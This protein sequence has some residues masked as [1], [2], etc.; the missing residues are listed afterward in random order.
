MKKSYK[1]F[2]LIELIVVITILSILWTIAFLSIRWYAQNS[3]DSVRIYDINNIKTSLELFKTKSWIYPEPSN[4][5][6]IFFSWSIAWSQWTFWESTFKNVWKLQKKPL[7]PLTLTEYTY[8]VTTKKNEYEIWTIIEWNISLNNLL[9]KS[10]ADWQYLWKSMIFWNYNWSVLSVSS[11]STLYVLA[12]PTIINWDMS[13]IDVEQILSQKKLAFNWSWNLPSSYSWSIMKWNWNFDFSPKKLVLFK[14]TKEELENNEAYKLILL[15]NIQL[16]YNW[17][18]LSQDSNL[19]PILSKQVN[20]YNPSENAKFTA[21]II[22]ENVTKQ[23][24]IDYNK[25]DKKINNK[26]NFPVWISKYT[27]CS[28]S[29][30]FCDD[31]IR[32]IF[33][34]SNWKMW[35]WSYEWWVWYFDWNNWSNYSVFDWLISNSI[36]SYGEDLNWNVWI[37]TWLWVSKA[38]KTSTWM[39]FEN[40]N[41]SD[42]LVWWTIVSISKDN[43]WKMWFW[44][45]TWGISIYDWVSFTNIT[46]SNNTNLLSNKIRDIKFDTNWNTWIATDLWLN[47]ILQ[48]WITWNNYTISNSNIISNNINTLL[49]HTNWK[50]FIWTNIW[51][52]IFDNINFEN[53][54]ISEGIGN[55]TVLWLFEDNSWAVWFWSTQW[56]TKYS[57]GVFTKYFTSNTQIVWDYIRSI[58]QDNSWKMWFWSYWWWASSLVWD[59]INWVWTTYKATWLVQNNVI[60]MQQDNEYNMWFATIWEWLSK[61]DWKKWDTYVWNPSSL[62]SSSVKNIYKDFDWNLWFV[63]DWYETNWWVNKFDWKNWSRLTTSDWLISN[64]ARTIFQDLDWNLWFWTLAWVSKYDWTSFIANYTTSNSNIIS[65]NIRSITQDNNWN[66]WFATDLWLSKFD[67]VNWNNYNSSN[68]LSKI[69]VRKIYND[70]KWILWIWTNWA[71]IKYDWNNFINI[72]IWLSSRNEVN[73]ILEDSN[74]N[75]W[76]A[77][78]I[79]LHKYNWNSWYKYSVASDSLISDNVNSLLEDVSWNIW[80]STWAWVNILKF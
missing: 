32:V 49:V 37:W 68:W 66:M 72:N 34:D 71:I 6:D 51:I 22:A 1:A 47:K 63:S 43:N 69:D 77:S 55:Y 20:I 57:L 53:H 56:V 42:W 45:D 61:F 74:W 5:W 17:T 24:Q 48:D 73:D 4:P 2:T 15:K 50:I 58:S 8:S 41:S 25:Y 44:S 18:I 23:K 21:W 12:V 60:S 30:S 33:A 62:I 7:D 10:F 46:T 26:F 36:H 80:I 3:R 9:Q 65:N 78:E 39:I 13:L 38:T 67:W 59:P 40:Y 31:D 79:W 76:I 75:I 19:I 11:W 52:S 28:T 16:A 70:S 27:S 29:T 54:W 35:F 64:D 14:W